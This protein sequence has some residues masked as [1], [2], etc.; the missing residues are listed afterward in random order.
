MLW[1]FLLSVVVVF[2]GIAVG[3]WRHGRTNQGGWNEKPLEGLRDFGTV[4]NFS[5]IERSG[6]RLSL[7]DLKG[8]TWIVDFIYTRCRDTCPLQSA[9]MAKLQADL[10]SSDAMKLV[11]VSVDPEWDT[12]EVLSRYAER[13]KADPQFWLFLT[14]DKNA[15]YRL[16]QEGFRLSAVPASG[17][18]RK[19]SEILHSSRFV[20]VDRAAQ[21]RGY[22]DSSDPEVLKR[23]R[24]DL[25]TL[26]GKDKT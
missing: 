20:L 15:I 13:Y 26:L 23:L 11:S 16:A 8:K 4:P 14:G 2:V 25:K 18:E 17:V 7:S 9:Q 6:K 1:G 5:L 24:R 19:G 10:S 12:P 21:I 3:T 22:Y